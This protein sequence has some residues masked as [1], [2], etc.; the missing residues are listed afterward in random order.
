MQNSGEKVPEKAEQHGRQSDA[1]ARFREI[2]REDINQLRREL[3]QLGMR[4]VRAARIL[5]LPREWLE[6]QCFEEED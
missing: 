4:T 3:K 5:G 2:N 1:L 6:T